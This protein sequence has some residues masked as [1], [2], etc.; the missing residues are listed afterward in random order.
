MLQYKVS[1]LARLQQS[2]QSAR[3][4]GVLRV[5]SVDGERVEFDTPGVA[6]E[7]VTR[8]SKDLQ[9]RGDLDSIERRMKVDLAGTAKSKG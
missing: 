4:Y 7:K 1:H 6:Y 2:P 8:A 5:R 9:K 3:M